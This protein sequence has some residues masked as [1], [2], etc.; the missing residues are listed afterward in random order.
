MDSLTL[1]PAPAAPLCN[2]R[3]ALGSYGRVAL[4]AR[5]QGASPH[6][7]VLLLFERLAQL[8]RRARAAAAAGDSAGRLMATERAIA[9]VEGLDATL[10]DDR[11]GDIAARLHEVYALLGERILL[12]TPEALGEAADCVATLADAWRTITPASRPG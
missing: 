9:I 3:V 7:L 6:A 1:A 10:D 4:E 8:L 5:V 12:A 11:G 2:P